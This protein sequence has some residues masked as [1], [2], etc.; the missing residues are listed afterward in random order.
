MLLTL[1]YNALSKTVNGDYDKATN[2]SNALYN[3]L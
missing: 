3:I 1:S 2:W